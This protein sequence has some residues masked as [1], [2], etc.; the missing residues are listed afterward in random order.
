MGLGPSAT[1]ANAF[2][3]SVTG[4]AGG[5]YLQFYIGD[6]GASGASNTAGSTT[7]IAV[8][9]PAASAG[10]ATQTGTATLTSWAGGSQTISH[11][12][13]WSASSGGT[14][15]GSFAFTASRAVING[16]DLVVS[17]LVVSAPR[18]T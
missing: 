15:R 5:G 6:P 7:R 2:V 8:A 10:S 18:A 11:G 14:F 3:D 1:N 9:F 13:F 12:A 4:A 17:G 16:D